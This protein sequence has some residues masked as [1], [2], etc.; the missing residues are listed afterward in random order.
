MASRK[1]QITPVASIIFAEQHWSDMSEVK[2]YSR[3][4]PPATSM[5]AKP[6]HGKAML[7]TEMEQEP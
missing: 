5:R 1:F 4:S 7:R 2:A 3:H 6:E